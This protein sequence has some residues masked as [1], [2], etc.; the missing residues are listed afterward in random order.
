MAA[1]NRFSIE[2]RHV[3]SMRTACCARLRQVVLRC[4]R[5]ITEAINMPVPAQIWHR[6]LRVADP[7]SRSTG[8]ALVIEV[9]GEEYICSARHLFPS[10]GTKEIHVRY[11]ERWIK[12]PVTV[13]GTGVPDDDIVVFKAVGN[14]RRIPPGDL[15]VQVSQT[16]MTFTQEA[17]VLGYPFGWESY[18]KGTGGSWPFPLVKRATV[19]GLPTRNHPR[20]LLLDCHVNPGFSGGAV[21]LNL[22]GTRDWAIVGVVA[23]AH[24]EPVDVNDSEHEVAI[25]SGF[26][27]A[28][29]IQCA[30]NIIA[31]LPSDQPPSSLE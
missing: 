3:A 19:A 10:A 11:D 1:V 29:D 17:Y 15:A 28:T 25:P 21:A 16:Q 22:L 4:G 8:T 5:A 23:A 14:W 6:I 26:S 13:V 27:V 9:A 18:D 12:L 7:E 31:G 30:V 20:Q 24:C 2:E